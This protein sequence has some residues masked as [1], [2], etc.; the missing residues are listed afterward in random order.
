MHNNNSK[1]ETLKELDNLF[2]KPKKTLDDITV[3]IINKI[4]EINK[5]SFVIMDMFKESEDIEAE[6][7]IKEMTGEIYD[8]EELKYICFQLSVTFNRLIYDK[9]VFYK[10]IN[11]KGI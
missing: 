3:E 10:N 2:I 6:Y 11:S 1:S 4:T 5:F 7:F 9:L 8:V